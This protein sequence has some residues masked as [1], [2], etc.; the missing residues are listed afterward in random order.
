M[1]SY[2]HSGLWFFR[3]NT[4]WSR[5][6]GK[7]N[8]PATDHNKYVW[9]MIVIVWLFGQEKENICLL[10]K[11]RRRNNNSSGWERI[12][13][14]EATHH[15]HRW[16]NELSLAVLWCRRT[17]QSIC[18][19]WSH[20]PVCVC[21]WNAEHGKTMAVWMNKSMQLSQKF[22]KISVWRELLCFLKWLQAFPLIWFL[23]SQIQK[24]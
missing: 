20:R 16:Q 18:S 6:A 5:R 3:V 2:I 21:E 9:M 7:M 23:T 14:H 13:D 11:T 12:R 4:N 8:I 1:S 19:T 10:M 15:L 22:S 17:I 24:H